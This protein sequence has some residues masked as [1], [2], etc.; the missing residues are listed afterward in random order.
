MYAPIRGRRRILT[1][2]LKAELCRL[3]AESVT[4]EAAADTLDVSLRT[5]QRER[6]NDEDFD[7]GLRLSLQAEPDP[8]RLM[9]TAARTH[10]RAAAWLLERTDPETYARRPVNTAN[11]R[12]VEAA[13]CFL[14]EAALQATPAEQRPAFFATINAAREHAFDCVFPNLGPWGN[15]R[16]P[17][18]PPSPLTDYFIAQQRLATAPTIPDYDEQGNVLPAPPRPAPPTFEE[19][20]AA[21]ATR[22]AEEARREAKRQAYRE[23]LRCARDASEYLDPIEADEAGEI[24]STQVEGILSPKIDLATEFPTPRS[25]AP[26]GNAPLDAPRPEPDAPANSA[27]GRPFIPE[28]PAISPPELSDAEQLSRWLEQRRRTPIHQAL[29]RTRNAKR[30]RKERAASKRRQ[31]AKR[32]ARRRAG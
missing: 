5:I 25:H 15:P 1:P 30:A 12:Q 10:W 27:A 29:E 23:Q 21:A 4:I 13:L 14:L 28:P 22:A 18:C 19:V 3:V 26:R 32:H 8:K 6:K 7:H 11:P 16:A 17:K 9:Q 20:Q 31:A 24:D 2:A